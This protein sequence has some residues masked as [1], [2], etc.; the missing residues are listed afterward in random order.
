MKLIC[1]EKFTISHIRP[2]VKRGKRVPCLGQSRRAR[3]LGEKAEVAGEFE[4]VNRVFL[5]APP[6]VDLRLSRGGREKSYTRMRVRSLNAE[7]QPIIRLKLPAVFGASSGYFNRDTRKYDDSV[8][9]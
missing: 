5:G 4:G 2:S 6:V 3:C 9:D 1:L 7:L 8:K